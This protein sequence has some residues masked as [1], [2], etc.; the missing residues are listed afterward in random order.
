MHCLGHSTSALYLDA[1][2]VTSA[3]L[4]R[5]PALFPR[6]ATRRPTDGGDSAQHQP[7]PRRRRLPLQGLGWTGPSLL[8]YLLTWAVISV[9]GREPGRTGRTFG[10]R[11]GGQGQRRRRLQL[12]GPSTRRTFC[13]SVVPA[14][15]HR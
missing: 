2:R 10:H 3:R 11:S 7:R 13:P 15:R 9:R 4:S 14:Q 5:N 12:R 1:G 6:P 8:T